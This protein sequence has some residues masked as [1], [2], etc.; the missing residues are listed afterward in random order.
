MKQCVDLLIVGNNYWI[1]ILNRILF[2]YNFTM[3]I[4]ISPMEIFEKDYKGAYKNPIAH[5]IRYLVIFLKQQSWFAMH[6]E[7]FELYLV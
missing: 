3:S 5:V 6:P 4:L 2:N 7:I 1:R